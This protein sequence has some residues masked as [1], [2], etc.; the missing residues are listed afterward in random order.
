MATQAPPQASKE[1]LDA[2]SAQDVSVLDGEA[3]K[4]VRAPLLALLSQRCCAFVLQSSAEPRCLCHNSTQ[5]LEANCNH[6]ATL[7][8]PEGTHPQAMLDECVLPARL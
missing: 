4:P 5:L 7:L 2:K 6:F 1:I 3:P 8:A